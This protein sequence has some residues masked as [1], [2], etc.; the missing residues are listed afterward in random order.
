MEGDDVCMGEA[1]PATTTSTPLDTALST[2]SHCMAKCRQHWLTGSVVDDLLREARAQRD[3]ECERDTRLFAA[4][5]AMRAHLSTLFPG[6]PTHTSLPELR[7][8]LSRQEAPQSVHEA[9]TWLDTHARYPCFGRVCASVHCEATHACASVRLQE[10]QRQGHGW[11]ITM[12]GARVVGPRGHSWHCAQLRDREVVLMEGVPGGGRGTSWCAVPEPEYRS[13][14][15]PHPDGVLY[16]PQQQLLPHHVWQH[17]ASWMDVPSLAQF[18]KVGKQCFN[19][20][21][22]HCLY[23]VVRHARVCEALRQQAKRLRRAREAEGSQWKTHPLTARGWDPQV[24]V[25]RRLLEAYTAY[26]SDFYR[27]HDTCRQE[28]EFH[29]SCEQA[30][31]T[32]RETVNKYVQLTS[33]TPRKDLE[34]RL[35]SLDEVLL[36]EFAHDVLDTP[37]H[38]A[39]LAGLP[40]RCFAESSKHKKQWRARHT[41]VALVGGGGTQTP[42]ILKVLK[43]EAAR[44]ALSMGRADIIRALRE[45]ERVEFA[46]VPRLMQTVCSV[47]PMFNPDPVHRFALTTS[48][49]FTSQE[50]HQCV[51]PL[52]AA[53]ESLA[54]ADVAVGATL[55][56][57]NRGL[58]LLSEG[59]EVDLV[60]HLSTRPLF[61]GEQNPGKVW[62]Q[63]L[64]CLSRERPKAGGVRM[65]LASGTH[66]C[67]R[68]QPGS[69]GSPHGLDLMYTDDMLG[70]QM[71]AVH[72]RWREGED[73][74]NHCGGKGQS[75]T[76]CKWAASS[77]DVLVLQFAGVVQVIPCAPRDACHRIRVANTLSALCQ[78][79]G[80][81]GQ[82]ILTPRKAAWALR[83]M[84]SH[85]LNLQ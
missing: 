36:R 7:L 12:V 5:A 1:A 15:I 72:G 42:G 20:A 81:L 35:R 43:F 56:R 4:G 78:S 14:Y 6:L 11:L 19:A 33:G 40:P 13:S 26:S 18:A 28:R 32:F 49:I 38:G 22:L 39:R 27:V 74:S 66:A 70:V 10:R 30:Q 82:R 23:P 65:R 29:T 68:A 57:M 67:S 62:L 41:Q 75:H 52:V 31:E 17:V 45:C 24:A 21:A 44:G 80:G 2:V 53:A 76:T 25:V 37:H 58:A 9:V 61:M 55:R 71:L 47:R 50:L 54:P 79:G 51:I 59:F 3:M 73:R 46:D 83:S 85:S 48:V 60:Q 64:S 34:V 69:R 16:Q 84:W 8:I 63:Y 77:L